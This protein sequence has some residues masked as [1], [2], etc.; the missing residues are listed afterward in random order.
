MK[1]MFNVMYKSDTNTDCLEAELVDELMSINQFYMNEA[2]FAEVGMSYFDNKVGP[3]IHPLFQDSFSSYNQQELVF[4]S[5]DRGSLESPCKSVT[6]LK[7]VKE[8]GKVI[9]V[10]KQVG[11]YYFEVKMPDEKRGNKGMFSLIVEMSDDDNLLKAEP[12]LAKMVNDYKQ[13]IMSH[14]EKKK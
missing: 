3:A 6:L 13:V 2:K 11:H 10:K 12:H 1:A 14:Y 9:L 7:A 5:L 8:E 4:D